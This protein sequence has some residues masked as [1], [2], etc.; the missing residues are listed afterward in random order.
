MSRIGR[1]PIKIPSGVNIDVKGTSI[2]VKGPKGA[3]ER[4]SNEH[5]KVTVADGTIT[6]ERDSDARASRAAHGLIRANVFA[7]VK[8][9]TDGFEKKLLIEG[10]GF[11][12]EV[13]GK[14]LMLTLGYSHPIEFPIPTGI[15]IAV[16]K[17][18]NVSVKGIDKQQVSQ[19]AAV[20]RAFRKPDAYK[21][22][23]IRYSDEKLRIKE[24]KSA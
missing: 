12:A 8:G 21:G 22:K 13:K 6:F 10:T 7:M 1:L 24:G 18:V 17:Q 5:V 16:E 4:A 20:I 15:D 11:R 19:V 2:K 9:V 23:G 14:S 3:I